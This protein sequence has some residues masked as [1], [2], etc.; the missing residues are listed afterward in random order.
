MF[1]IGAYGL[2]IGSSSELERFRDEFRLTCSMALQVSRAVDCQAYIR[3]RSTARSESSFMR[4]GSPKTSDNSSL[5]VVREGGDSG[6]LMAP[7]HQ[8]P[9][10][11]MEFHVGFRRVPLG[12]QNDLHWVF[13][14][15]R[16]AARW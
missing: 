11:H 9:P 4:H 5:G 12:N 1:M 15:D 2:A 6:H 8:I 13:L 16:F 3:E 10:E 14:P 7:A